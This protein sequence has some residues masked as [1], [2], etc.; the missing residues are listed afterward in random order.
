MWGKGVH[1][2]LSTTRQSSVML[3][4]SQAPIPYIL[5]RIHSALGFT[6]IGT[7]I[8]VTVCLVG[9]VLIDQILVKEVEDISDEVATENVMAAFKSAV[10]QMFF[11]C[12]FAGTRT[13]KAGD[14]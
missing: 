10:I 8:L 1:L 4:I 9:M 11:K 5:T 6:V 13:W 3:I 12:F 14:T 2:F 7:W